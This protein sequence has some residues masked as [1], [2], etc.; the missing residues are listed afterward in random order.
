MDRVNLTAPSSASC[1]S[2]TLVSRALQCLCFMVLIGIW[3][4]GEAQTFVQLT[5]LGQGI[6]ARLTTN[7][8][9]QRLSGISLFGQIGTKVS[10]IDHAVVYQFAS[11]PAWGR[12]LSGRMDYWVHEYDNRTGPGGR[13]RQPSG[14]DISARKYFYAADRAKGAI[15]LAQFSPAAENLTNAEAW[16]NVQF[17]RPVDVAWDGSTTPL[18]ADYLYVLDDSL[19]RVSYWDLS[20]R[21]WPNLLW[22]YGASGSGVGQ[23]KRPSGVCV[24]KTVA[25]NGGT[26]FTTN[27][28]V[29]DRGNRRVVWLNRGP[30]GPTW[31]G[32]ISLGVWDPTD[33]A[34]DHFGN[35]H[36]SDQLSHRL[37]KFTYTLSPLTAY[38]SYGKGATNLNT[39]A[40]PRAVSVP[41]GLKTVNSQ[42]VWYC[43]GRIITAED[44]SE[45]TGAVEHY[46]GIDGAVTAQ[47]QTSQY[48]DAWFSYRTTDHG[49]HMLNVVDVSGNYVRT[50]PPAGLL[51]PGT[52]TAY[53]DGFRDNGTPAP[54]GTYW[55]QVTATSGYGCSGQTWCAKGLSTQTFF[56][57]A[58]GGCGGPCAPP[59]VGGV[60]D[61]AGEPATVF[62]R[63]RIVGAPSPLMRLSGPA[64]Q[65]RAATATSLGSLTAAVR[66][67]GVR[68][69]SFGV[70]RD[71]AGQPLSIHVFSL[72]GR[73]IRTLVNEPLQ[74]GYYDLA[75][76]GLDDAGRAVAPGVYFAA[77]TVGGHRIVQRLIIR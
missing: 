32:T 7:V 59:V 61:S 28:Y 52:R 33:C 70:P 41:C 38:G 29:V 44:W 25:S 69:L 77:L 36:V 57:Q 14:I 43:E 49:T 8:A 71:A 45:S 73:R 3:S 56:H 9:K 42:T 17:P 62:L 31:M 26:Q 13:L 60:V 68:G 6:G 72:A 22:W 51:P 19:S 55:F 53:W 74:P 50:I 76:D 23:L 12:I 21:A 34:V 5:D 16:S 47:P 20:N 2:R 58:G 39:F 65:T 64:D 10:Y 15:F 40:F 4:R 67:Q 24:G 37:H 27:F 30:S 48:G 66:E 11:D 54:T 1:G 18:T 63:Q 35:L 75:W 46:L